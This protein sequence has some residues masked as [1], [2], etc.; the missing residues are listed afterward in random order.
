MARGA[1]IT[2][3]GGEG[4]G[5][6]TSLTA[7][8]RCLQGHGVDP[9]VTREPGGT[10]LGESIRSWI[11]DG[12]H[13]VLSAEVEAL[14]M[15]AARAQH[16]DEII[17]PA[18]EIGKWVVCDRFTDATRAYQGGGRGA[19][20]ALL[21]AL[22][23]GV[24]QG[25]NP[26]LTLLLDAPVEVGMAR[27]ADRPHDHFERESSEFLDRVRHAYLEMAAAEPDRFRI[28]D[29]TQSQDAVQRAIECEIEGFLQRYGHRSGAE[30]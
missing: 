11:L 5:K 10:R 4:V 2:L 7:M 19:S 13:G 29:A 26:D 8:R 21:D 28:I 20:V 23:N 1:F 15:F 6:S 12:E 17:R 3:E 18:L 9:V 16:L 27:I 14:L 25:L 30:R 24:Q 22:A